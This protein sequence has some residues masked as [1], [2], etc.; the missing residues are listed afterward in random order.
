MRSLACRSVRMATSSQV[1]VGRGAAVGN[2]PCC[3]KHLPARRCECDGI[4][5][6]TDLVLVAANLGKQGENTGECEWRWDYQYY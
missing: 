3:Y 2:H 5:N 1:G 4:V 6:I